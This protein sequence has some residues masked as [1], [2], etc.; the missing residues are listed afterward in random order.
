R[1][2]RRRGSGDGAPGS[3]PTFCA[4]RSRANSSWPASRSTRCRFGLVTRT[5]GRPGSTRTWLRGTRT[6]TVLAVNG[7][8]AL[9]HLAKFAHRLV[10]LGGGTVQELADPLAVLQ[11]FECEPVGA[12]DFPSAGLHA[13][14]VHL[15]RA[16]EFGKLRLGDP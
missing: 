13:G 11:A 2:S 3:R 6:L 9:E 4:I 15:T 10:P 8:F 7:A 5:R 14:D 16:A 12:L 1:S